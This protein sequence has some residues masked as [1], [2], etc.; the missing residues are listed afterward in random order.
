M[1]DFA[2]D[3]DPATGLRSAQFEIV[4]NGR[5]PRNQNAVH[6]VI[7][8][9]LV[10]DPDKLGDYCLSTLPRRVDDL[11]IIAGAAAFADKATPRRVAQSWSRKLNVSVPVLD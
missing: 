6:C 8:Q 5:R 3:V 2:C 11:V 7:G 4:E 9:H 10:I 1:T